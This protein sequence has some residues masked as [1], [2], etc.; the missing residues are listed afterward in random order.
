MT[1]LTSKISP[2]FLFIIALI[3]VVLI[4]ETR[5]YRRV[6]TWALPSIS[7]VFG[8][9]T[10]S[11]ETDCGHIGVGGGLSIK[12][13]NAC[14]LLSSKTTILR[15]IQRLMDLRAWPRWA[16]CTKKGHLLQMHSDIGP[17][18]QCSSSPRYWEVNTICR[19]GGKSGFALDHRDILGLDLVEHEKQGGGL[20]TEREK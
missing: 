2:L 3:R 9:C 20:Y 10:N 4:V 13:L 19:T 14:H 8:S 15:P 7:A 11:C 12:I 1:Y 5:S 18:L 16:W 6:S 17:S